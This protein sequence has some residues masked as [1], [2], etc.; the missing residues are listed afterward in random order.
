M[1][2]MSEAVAQAETEAAIRAAQAELDRAEQLARLDNDPTAQTLHALRVFL[3][4]T[5]AVIADQRR[6]LTEHRL[7]IDRDFNAVRQ[8]RDSLVDI[9]N[10]TVKAAKAEV[11]AAH[12]DVAR[13]VAASIAGSAEQRLAA[14]S[15]WVW[16]RTLTIGSALA[17]V[18]LAVGFGLGYWRGNAAGYDQAATAIQ[19]SGPVERAVLSAQGPAGLDQWHELMH[20]NGILDTMKTDCTGGNIAHQDGRT[21]CHLWLWTTPYVASAAHG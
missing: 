17:I 2:A 21:A 13:R 7:H 8:A 14:L 15:R 18:I 12:A 10:Q 19:A 3:T 11:E 6:Y 1:D 9:A 5:A 4:S 16:W 20:D